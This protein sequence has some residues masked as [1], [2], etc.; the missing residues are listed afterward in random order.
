MR[1][2]PAL[3]VFERGAI[4]LR[5]RRS[6]MNV[7]P[8]AIWIVCVVTSLSGCHTMRPVALRGGQPLSANVAPGDRA[9]VWLQDGRR[10]ELR[11]TAVETDAL[12]SG[13]QRIPLKDIERI[14]IRGISWTRTTLLLVGIGVTLFLISHINHV[15]ALAPPACLVSEISGMA[16]FTRPIWKGA[17]SETPA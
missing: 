3:S 13:E 8:V 16:A 12:V 6:G 9:R 11:V 17:E 14:E 7:R 5:R 1:Q 15:F 2:A 4:L 10:P